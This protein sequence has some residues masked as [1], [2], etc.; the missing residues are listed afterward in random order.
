MPALDFIDDVRVGRRAVVRLRPHYNGRNAELLS[1][2]ALELGEIVFG[3][4]LAVRDDSDDRA[5]ER[6]RP[7]GWLRPSRFH[8]IGGIKDA[9]DHEP[10]TRVSVSDVIA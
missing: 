2:H 7:R 10:S 9:K 5:G 6:G 8:L 1:Q 4:F 3:A